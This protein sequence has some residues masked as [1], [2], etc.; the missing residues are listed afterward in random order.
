VADGAG[1]RLFFLDFDGVI[2]DSLSECYEV[3][4]VAYYGLHLEAAV[5]GPSEEDERT[6]RRLRPYVRRGG[7]YLFIQQCLHLKIAIASQ[8]DFDA[9]ATKTPG[10]DDRYHELFYRARRELLASDPGRWFLLNPLYPG[11][12]DL[13]SRLARDG[14]ALVLSTKEADFIAKIL[15]FN[16]LVWP[17]GCIYCSGKERKLAFI[18]RVMDELGADRAVFV[19]DQVDHFKGGSVHSVRCLLADWG[20]VRAEWLADGQTETVSLDGLGSALA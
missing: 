13:L 1:R 6:F 10:L 3:S 15:E 19:D 2:C 14:G 18:D 11:M 20:Y 4:R 9:V 5:P 17:Y 8:V 16:G 7:D 12:K